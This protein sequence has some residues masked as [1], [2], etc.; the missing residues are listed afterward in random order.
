M[1]ATI[2]TAQG[3]NFVVGGSL[4]TEVRGYLDRL[5]VNTAWQAQLTTMV[6][7]GRTTIIISDDQNDLPQ[8]TIRSL[9]YNAVYSPVT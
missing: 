2:P 9:L 1:V 4:V 8:G 6:A 3:V 5:S 7:A